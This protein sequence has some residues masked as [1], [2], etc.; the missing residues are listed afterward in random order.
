MWRGW[1]YGNLYRHQL[2]LLLVFWRKTEELVVSVAL[3][4]ARLWC[5]GK[6]P[7]LPVLFSSFHY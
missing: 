2:G 1:P 7:F 5:T 4:A 6:Q 3:E